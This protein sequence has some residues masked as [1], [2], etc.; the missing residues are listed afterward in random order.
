LLKTTLGYATHTMTWLGY[1]PYNT[2]IKRRLKDLMA[3]GG[4]A[5]QL[6]Q[7]VNN[8]Y[9]SSQF[10]WLGQQLSN[11]RMY[12]EAIAAFSLSIAKDSV[13][14]PAHL[15]L[16]EAY[17]NNRQKAPAIKHLRKALNLSPSD[18]KLERK[19]KLLQKPEVIVT[20]EA[21]NTYVGKYDSDIGVLMIT[22]EEGVL[23][24]QLVGNL[25]EELLPETNEVFLSAD[26]GVQVRFIQ[27]ETGA[28]EIEI[29]AGNQQFIARKTE[30]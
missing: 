6:L 30:G 8:D 21:A 26:A 28:T 24:V 27:K 16:G 23:Y 29:V 19:V 1:E 17:W 5:T 22:Y 10:N 25:K 20:P 12:Q 15:G 7:Q 9:T 11:R 3:Q 4:N 18:N 2:P 13:S 14:F